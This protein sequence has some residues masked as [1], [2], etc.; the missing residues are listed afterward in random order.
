MIVNPDTGLVTGRTEVE[1]RSR[2]FER[3]DRSRSDALIPLIKSCL[4]NVPKNRPSIVRV[5]DQLEGQLVDN[6][7]TS[8]QQEIHQKDARKDAELLQK[9]A[10][11]YQ[12]DAEIQRIYAEIQHK[13]TQLQS[14]NTELQSNRKELQK[15]NNEMQRRDTEIQQLTVSLH[16]KDEMLQTLISEMSNLKIT[17]SPSL[18]KEVSE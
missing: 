1:R 12:K 17:N 7:R 4:S 13:D 16:D 6:E 3:I 2:Y 11:I 8:R 15:K 9:D 18:P 14:K 10:E 5:C